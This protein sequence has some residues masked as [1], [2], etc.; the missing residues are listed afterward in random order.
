MIQ[1]RIVFALVIAM[2]IVVSSAVAGS[3]TGK[4]RL[5]R[6]LTGRNELVRM[7]ALLRLRHDGQQ[8]RESLDD[9]IAAVKL[10]SDTVGDADLPPSMVEMVN[11]IGSVDCPESEAALIELLDSENAD[12][13][14]IGADSLGRHK[15]FGAIEH[16]RRQ[17]DRP[18]YDAR[19][20]F[21]FNLVRSLALMQHPDAIEI[22]G[23]LEPTL[24]GQLRFEIERLLKEVTLDDFRGDEKRYEQWQKRGEK[25]AAF[26][27]ANFSK[28]S[29]D[30]SY[31]PI[32]FAEPRQYYGIDIHAQRVMFVI[33]HSGSMRAPT[34]SGTRLMRA[35]QELIRAILELPEESEFA[36]VSFDS[37][38]RHWRD[39]L[40]PA[41]ED[42]KRA[43]ILYVQRLGLGNDTNTYG[44]LRRALD[45][46]D[47]L[48]AIYLL[49][50]GKP[51]AGQIINPALIAGDIVHR[52]RWRHL[53][54]NTI[55]IS[56]G[57]PTE[58]FLRS[59]A[60]N[61]GGE[62]RAAQ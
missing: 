46:D 10:H 33:D 23:E 58:S 48:E 5:E 36:I 56:V 50:D 2:G 52:N 31:D 15:F 60:V 19:Y 40:S 6:V 49:T 30:E 25:D 61:S 34:S 20:A 37:N 51:T 22:L 18:E 26:R 42:D 16:L 43:A 29:D 4:S 27:V 54:I 53:N 59:L 7:N 44:A 3:P 41:T 12:I 39:K 62:F 9:L 1:L 38:V 14:M 21:R 24:D 8:L 11:L 57:G 55:G 28:Q 17:I 13:A 35:K 47:A 32:A 45:F